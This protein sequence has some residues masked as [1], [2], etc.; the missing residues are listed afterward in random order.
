LQPVGGAGA[1]PAPPVDPPL[2][3]VLH[4]L[5][6]CRVVDT[7]VGLLHTNLLA[8]FPSEGSVDA[9]VVF[10]KVHLALSSL[11]MSTSKRD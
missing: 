9:H 8:I 2:L 3:G 10:T 5:V 6:D 11:L 7:V 1:P 4:L